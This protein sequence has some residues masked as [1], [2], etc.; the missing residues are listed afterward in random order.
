[1][2][3]SLS[4]EEH[5]VLVRASQITTPVVTYWAPDTNSRVSYI[6]GRGT[7]VLVTY[8]G[9]HFVVTNTHVL[10]RYACLRRHAI[11]V[12]VQVM[13][14]SGM[15]GPEEHAGYLLTPRPKEQFELSV[16]SEYGHQD[17]GIIELTK[18]GFKALKGAKRFLTIKEID[19]SSVAAGE[20][21]MYKG[22][23]SKS[24]EFHG[25]QR[26]LF[27]FWAEFR[28]VTAATANLIV[29]DGPPIATVRGDDFNEDGSDLQ[30]ISGAALLD[31]KGHLRGI[32]WGGYGGIQGP[33]WSVPSGTLV[34]IL[35]GYITRQHPPSQA[36]SA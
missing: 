10:E 32:V 6:A 5:R 1:M 33:I 8:R 3:L 36:G 31:M 4:R 16:R 13:A 9:R 2:P 24:A 28:T 21:V 27:A 25:S 7:G 15:K 22:Y 26:G 11:P 23:P 19:S 30:G 18:N 14:G 17:V 20:K 35:D 12:A 34:R 29:S